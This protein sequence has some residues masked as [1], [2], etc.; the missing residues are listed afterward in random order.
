MKRKKIAVEEPVHTMNMSEVIQTCVAQT[1]VA[2]SLLKSIDPNDWYTEFM[3]VASIIIDAQKVLSAA[4]EELGI[5][6]SA[7]E[8]NAPLGMELRRVHVI[9]HLKERDDD[10]P[11]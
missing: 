10:L 4:N 8:F 11:F 2:I 1:V 9:S 3:S 6:L 5:G 7:L